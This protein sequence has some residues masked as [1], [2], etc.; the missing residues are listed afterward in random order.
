MEHSKYYIIEKKNNSYCLSD[1]KYMIIDQNNNVYYVYK[2]GS[3]L[4]ANKMES[5][6]KDYWTE[7]PTAEV[8]LL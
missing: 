4:K 6:L 8:V 1:L 3:K 5:G 7:I 2:D